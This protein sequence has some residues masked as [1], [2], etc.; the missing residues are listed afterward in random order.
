[1][2]NPNKSKKSLDNLKENGD[3]AATGDITVFMSH[4]A[5]KNIK[6]TYSFIKKLG[7]GGFGTV[8][9]AKN[10]SNNLEYAVK[11]ILKNSVDNAESFLIEVDIAKKIR[12]PNIIR[13]YESY[14]SAK[15]YF[16]VMELCSGGELLDF[17]SDKKHLTENDTAKVMK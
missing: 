11:A 9:L 3:G 14:E 12:H 16:L 13:V 5:S 4:D 10:K 7:E 8:Y 15:H 1:M 17:I 2:V 6:I